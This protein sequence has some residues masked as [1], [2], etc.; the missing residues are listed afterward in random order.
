M[1]HI[2]NSCTK[3]IEFAKSI[4][5]EIKIDNGCNWIWA[6]GF[7][8]KEDAKKFDD[9]CCANGCETRGVYS[10]QNNTANVRFR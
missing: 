8:S 10:G 6:T 4:N 5:P 2:D 1:A 3:A 7:I 9:Y